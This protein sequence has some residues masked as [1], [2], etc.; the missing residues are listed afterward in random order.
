MAHVRR[1]L[2]VDDD[3]FIKI[4]LSLELPDVDLLEASRAEEAMAIAMN[5]TLDVILVDRRLPDGDGLDLIRL[6]RAR[7]ALHQVP[8]I[9]ITAGHD[10]AERIA[11]LR[12]GADEYLGKPIEPADLR[13]RIE[14]VLALPRSEL[15]TRRAG[16]IERLQQGEY[17]DIDPPPPP[18]AE[19]ERKGRFRRLFRS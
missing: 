9:L 6:L 7:P 4:T 11:V 15:R 18:P 12:S 2:V 13:A 8:I 1:A 19:P 3:E 5:E 17:G 14:R 10:E 16:L